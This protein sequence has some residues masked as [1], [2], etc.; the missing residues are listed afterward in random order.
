MQPKSFT[1]DG[2]RHRISPLVPMGQIKWLVGRMHVRDSDSLIRHAIEKRAAAQ[3]GWTK[4]TTEQAVKFAIACHRENQRL[5]R[6]FR[7]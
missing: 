6:T 4:A 1:L 5:F 2:K 7:F 3:P